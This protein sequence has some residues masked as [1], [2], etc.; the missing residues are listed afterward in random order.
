M[1]FDHPAVKKGG[2]RVFYVGNVMGKR[3]TEEDV[4][5]DLLSALEFG[6]EV[7]TRKV[8]RALGSG[9]S[10]HGRH[11]VNGRTEFGPVRGW[12]RSLPAEHDGVACPSLIGTPF[13]AGTIATVLGLNPTVIGDI[14]Y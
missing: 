13:G 10:Q 3:F 1:A 2:L 11:E 7:E 8:M 14:D 9:G 12:D 5:L 6:E 4:A